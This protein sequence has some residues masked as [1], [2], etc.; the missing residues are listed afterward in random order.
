MSRWLLLAGLILGTLLAVPRPA[1]SCTLCGLNLQMAPT[2][3]QE[4]AQSSAK[5]IVYGT[6][7][8]PKLGS[9]GAGTTELQIS[10]V[11]RNDPIL[12][13]D[14]KLITLSRYIPVDR[15][16]PPRFLVF[17]DVFMNRLDDYRGV[18]IK[19]QDGVRY[20]ER[21]LQ[22]DNRD[23]VAN[24]QFFF[25][26]LDHADQEL[27]NDAYM[28]F[29][30]STDSL[31]GQVAGKLPVDR[32]RTWVSQEKTPS[33]RLA[34]YAF[35]LGAAGGE[36]DASLLRT[37]LNDTGERVSN[38]HHGILCGLMNL[39]PNEGWNLAHDILRDGRKNLQVRLSVI[40]AVR[41]YHGW[42]PKEYHEQVLKAIKILIAQGELADMAVDDL[43]KWQIW[44]LTR[45]VLGLYSM[46]GFDSPIL[47][48]AII[49]YALSCERNQDAIRFLEERRK[50][51]PK[52]VSE[53]E[54]SLKR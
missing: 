34:L 33:D 7:Q 29:A 27:A 54:E 16:N 11:L 8:N 47:K 52:L 26:Y 42:K 18:P 6:L 24:L 37:M 31:I 17:C 14:P 21:L 50:E 46:K 51:D 53:I 19:T 40:R 38:A 2:L 45:E 43:R 30:K 20:V 4:A 9:G 1:E 22:M 49:R 28:E 15:N 10:R 36:Q 12:G 3:R 48:D 13:K 35:M 23:P 5:V 44:D 41:F 32:L 25:G 39:K